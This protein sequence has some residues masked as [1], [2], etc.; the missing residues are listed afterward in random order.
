MYKLL[1]LLILLSGCRTVINPFYDPAWEKLCRAGRV[2]EAEWR[3]H[4][5]SRAIESL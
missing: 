3:H 1:I 4:C 2:T 5:E